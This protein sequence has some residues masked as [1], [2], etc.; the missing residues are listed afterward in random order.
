VPSDELLH[1]L[2]EGFAIH[3]ERP[4]VVVL[5]HGWT[6]SPAHV[7]LLADDLDA[8]GF[9][10]IAPLLAGHGTDIHDILEVS[11]RE[12]VESAGTAA[13]RV[14]DSGSRLH[15]A[16]LSMGGV[17]SILLATAFEAAS[18]TTINAPIKVR[19]VVAHVARYLMGG[20]HRVWQID[21][22]ETSPDYA[23][24]FAHQYEGT[25]LGS[26]ADL[27]TL[28]DAAKLAL[29]RVTVPALVVQARSDQVVRP[30]SGPYIYDHIGSLDKR[31][32]WLERSGHVAT[33]DS[34]RHHVAAEV[35]RHLRDA[36]EPAS[37]HRP[38]QDG[39]D[40]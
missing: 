38:R 33:L 39:Y 1:P 28:I 37:P 26:V 21:G 23:S 13:Q 35:I 2:A 10:V 8:A 16:G 31:L 7:R 14:L 32:V 15:L 36:A 6:G 12:W 18:V 4:D 34:E 19:G 3:D 30:A 25:P 24:D 11:W 40:E 29:P 9:G 20:S 5:L 22:P 17:I 27:F